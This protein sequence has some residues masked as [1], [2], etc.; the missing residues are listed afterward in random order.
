MVENEKN[1]VHINYFIKPGHI[2]ISPSPAIIS[3]VLGSCVAICIYDNNLKISG[4]NHFKH[5]KTD[6]PKHATADYGNIATLALIRMMLEH[7]SNEGELEAQIFGGAFNDEISLKDVG[8]ENIT[9]ASTILKQKN[10]PIVSEDVSGKKGRKIIFD[11]AAKEIAVLKVDK[12][13]QEDW[14]PYEDTR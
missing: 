5:P 4:M 7:G 1:P 10:I 13:R 2:Y 8:R 12:L 3:T 6:N 14:Y 9:V 11:T